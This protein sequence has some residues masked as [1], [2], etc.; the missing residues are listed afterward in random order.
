MNMKTFSELDV[1]N[2]RD[3]VVIIDVDGTLTRDRG[4]TV[5]KDSA[6]KLAELAKVADV[7]LSS[8]APD[9]R[10][11]AF[12][13]THGVF[14]LD[15]RHKKPSRRVLESLG[16]HREKL[17]VIGDKML[18]DGLFALNIGAQFVHVGRVRH[19]RD[20]HLM[21][22]MY[23]F[24]DLVGPFLRFLFPVLPYVILMRPVHWIKNGLVFTPLFFAG[25]FADLSLVLRVSLAAIVF[26][27]ASSAMYVLNDLIDREQDRLHPSKRGRPLASGVANE[28]GAWALFFL[29]AGG[30]GL[31]LLLVPSIT[32]AILGYVALNVLYS[33]YLKHVAV[34]DVAAVSVS[35]VLRVV[36][37]GLATAMFVSPWIIWC[38]FFGALLVI[39][40]KR[41]AEF[42][43]T[44]RRRVLEKYSQGL[45]DFL[46]VS[47]GALAVLSYGL[48]TVLGS[49]SPYAIYST[50]FVAAGVLRFLH[51]AEN[52]ADAEYPETLM[53]RDPWI[54]LSLTLWVVFM[55]I[56]LYL[57]PR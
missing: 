11:Q 22:G 18:T 12:A 6:Q 28:R 38:V 30:V 4:E 45:L 16:S 43:R 17:F 33:L 7:Y 20:P 42:M 39:V 1:E 8:N 15:T 44:P 5:E 32:P 25:E 26:C 54:F 41:R 46:L 2:F 13:E 56:L 21:R 40:K 51:A 29:L 48:Y 52:S 37:G 9:A 57:F 36:A 50:V 34:V 23:V 10:V 24:D 19:A 47:A 3:S 53:F 49:A 55:F 27:A 14:Y 31:G 35:Y